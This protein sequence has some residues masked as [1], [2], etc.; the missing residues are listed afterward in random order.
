MKKSTLLLLL[1]ISISGFAQNLS[2][3]DEK[4]GFNKFKLGS[5]IQSYNKDLEFLFPDK[6]TGTKYYKYIK[7][8]ISIFGYTNID[9]IGLGFYKD[10]LYTIDIVLNPNGN[11]DMYL[12]ILSKLKGLFGYPT[13]ITSGSDHGELD[14]RTYMENVNQWLSYKTL[15]GL[16]KVKCSSPLRPCTLNVFLVSQVIEREINNDGF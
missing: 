13:T 7:K 10:K 11:D 3:L 4:Y 12:S 6:K 8:D 9:Q 15:L 2:N 16:N 5:S 1:L 14:T